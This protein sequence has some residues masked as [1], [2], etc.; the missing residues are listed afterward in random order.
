[1]KKQD[2]FDTTTLEDIF[3]KTSINDVF[4]GIE[5]NRLTPYVA[6][7]RI[8]VQL[9]ADIKKKIKDLINV[10]L[11][12]L[13]KEKKPETKIIEK[14]INNPT[15]VIIKE[16]EVIDNTKEVIKAYEEKIKKSFEDYEKSGR[17]M[18]PI[19]VPSPIANQTGNGGKVLSTDGNITKWITASSSSGSVSTDVYTPTNVITTRSFDAN[20]T[21]L[22]QLADVLGSLIA[23]L[24]SAGIIQ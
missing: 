6:P 21:S 7:P 11:A 19:V 1:M 15:K 17:G 13:P 14:T 23:S 4:D 16:K 3:D 22:D 10:E 5:E 8:D 24:Q 20:N 9:N 2:L 18:Y 12:K